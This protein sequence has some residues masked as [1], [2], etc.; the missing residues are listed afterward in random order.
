MNSWVPDSTRRSV[1]WPHLGLT[2]HEFTVHKAVLN[3]SYLVR[4]EHLGVYNVANYGMAQFFVA[5]GQIEVTGGGSGTLEL[6]L[7]SRRV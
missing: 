2:E 6:W 3:G 1:N 7:R 5:C 4:I